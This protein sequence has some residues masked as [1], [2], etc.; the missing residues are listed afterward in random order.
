MPFLV[1]LTIFFALYLTLDILATKMESGVTLRSAIVFYLAVV[2]FC[3]API[4]FGGY[5]INQDGAAHA[6]NAWIMSRLVAGDS[7]FTELYQINSFAVPNSIGH[8]I[9]AGLLLVVSPFTATKIM[10]VGIFAGSVAAAGYLRYQTAGLDGLRTAMLIGAAVTMN[11]LWANG[12]YNFYI[13]VIIAIFGI[14][15]FVKWREKLTFGRTFALA[16]ILLLAYFSHLIAVAAL[17]GVVV[18]LAL[19]VSKERRILTLVRTLSAMIPL[20]PLALIYRSMT[21]SSE[22]RVFPT[23]LFLTDFWSPVA[24]FNQLRTA[25]PFMLIS[26]KAIPLITSDLSVY[27]AVFSPLIYLGGALLLLLIYSIATKNQVDEGR[28]SNSIFAVLFILLT[29][30]AMFGP[31]HFGSQHGSLLRQRFL[32]FG[33]LLFIP[34]FRLVS[35][36]FSIIAAQAMLV[37]VIVFQTAALADYCMHSDSVSRKFIAAES[38]IPNTGGIASVEV[39]EMPTRYASLPEIHISNLYGI[40][41]N[42]IIWD[43]Y[44]I[45]HYLFPVVAAKPEDKEFAYLFTQNSSLL[46][47][48]DDPPIEEK[49]AILDRLFDEQRIDVLIVSGELPE[50]NA[51]IVR[52]F[53]A[54]PFYRSENLRLFR[55]RD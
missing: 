25:D 24:W 4:V 23:W 47:K 14:A 13:G 32:I 44:E 7:Q 39:I 49:L 28:P 35:R 26:H 19:Q 33:F 29:L 12:F 53:D 10:V 1:T 9:L 5:F 21:V 41:R 16:V 51:V 15:L 8:W 42:L 52:H 37:F 11:W 34:A 17:A 30:A 6:N 48:G 18:V 46:S 2:V 3:T 50:L 36:G 40:K 27:F 45:G 20:V 38:A 54:E 31:D 22:A 55:R 43:N